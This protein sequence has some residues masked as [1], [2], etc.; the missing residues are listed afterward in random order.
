VLADELTRHGALVTDLVAYR[1]I[2]ESPDAP[3]V[4]QLYRMLL[5]GRVDAVIFAS[6]TGVQRFA[7]LIGREQTADLLNTTTVAAMG[8]VTAAAAAE[9]GISTTVMPDTYTVD[10]LVQALVEHLRSAEHARL[11]NMSSKL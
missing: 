7:S 5:E 1:T 4:Q 9:L 10:G 11:K 3:A 8:P 6:P 2:P